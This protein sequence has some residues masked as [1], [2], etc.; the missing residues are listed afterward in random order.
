MLERS[1]KETMLVELARFHE[2]LHESGGNNRGPIID[3]WTRQL[4]Q[5]EGWPWC[6]IFVQQMA[7]MTDVLFDASRLMTSS[8]R[9]S[10]PH[11]AHVMT[12]WTLTESIYRMEEPRPGMLAIWRSGATQSGHVGIVEAGVSRGNFTTIEGNTGGPD[13]R[14]G[15]AVARRK[16]TDA[17]RGKLILQ[18][19]VPVWR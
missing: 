2:G 4:F 5:A 8:F 15:D 1:C 19:F 9:H 7:R 18:G 6:L 11:T 14:E 17:P 12:L 3:L 13:E 16:C 10:L